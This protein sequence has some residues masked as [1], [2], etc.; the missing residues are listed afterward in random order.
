MIWYMMYGIAVGGQHNLCRA[1]NFFLIQFVA[2]VVENNEHSFTLN[3]RRAL[4]HSDLPWL[5]IVPL[6]PTHS[7]EML[8]AIGH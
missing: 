4:D 7:V 5:V 2:I 6:I 1:P 8:P 3:V